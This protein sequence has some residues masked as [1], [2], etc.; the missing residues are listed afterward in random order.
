MAISQRSPAVSYSPTR[1]PL[2]YHRR[3]RS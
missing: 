3:R 2:Q 1:S